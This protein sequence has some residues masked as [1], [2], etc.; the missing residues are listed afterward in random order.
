MAGSPAGERESR[1]SPNSAASSTDFDVVLALIDAARVRAVNAVNTQLIELY[2][3]IGEHISRRTTAASWGKDTVESLAE[4]FRHRQPNVRGFSAS[5]PWRMMQFFDTY[6]GR[7][8]LVA[9]L[10]ELPGGSR[11]TVG[12]ELERVDSGCGAEPDS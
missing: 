2:W 6:R 5:N 8:N 12:R 7:P 9:L 4:H 1:V 3:S 10:R 11:R